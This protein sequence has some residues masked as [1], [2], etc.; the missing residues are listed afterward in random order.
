MWVGGQ[1]F[2]ASSAIKEGVPLKDQPP[3]AQ[4]PTS[5]VLLKDLSKKNDHDGYVF[6]MAEDTLPVDHVLADET[7]DNLRASA[8]GRERQTR[9]FS[10]LRA[11][12]AANS[13]L[14]RSLMNSAPNLTDVAS[15]P[16]GAGAAGRGGDR[17]ATRKLPSVHRADRRARDG[18]RGADGTAGDGAAGAGR[19]N[20][21]ASKT[22]ALEAARQAAEDPALVHYSLARRHGCTRDVREMY[23]ETNR[24]VPH[25]EEGLYAV[26]VEAGV[27]EEAE[28]RAMRERVPTKQRK[29]NVDNDG[30][31]RKTRYYVNK[32]HRITN[33]HLENTELGRKLERAMERSAQGK[34]VGDGGM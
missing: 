20:S 9:A 5:V 14:A 17:G 1:W 29:I 25:T 34:D 31:P 10:A 15:A 8:A 18:D 30:K 22:R 11:C 32:K 3:R 16:A 13:L 33:T 23:L 24:S 21:L 4:A 19:P 2:R 6:P 27:M 26:M 7:R 12:G 28:A